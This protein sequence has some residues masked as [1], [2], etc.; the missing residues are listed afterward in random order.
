M[1]EYTNNINLEI[2]KDATETI[3]SINNC[4]S[5]VDITSYFIDIDNDLKKINFEH[6]NCVTKYKE[7]INT[8]LEKIEELK[9]ELNELQY[10]LQ[11]SCDNFTS[12]EKNQ[13][14]EIEYRT[15]VTNPTEMIHA[16]TD[17]S[18]IPPVTEQ[19]QTIENNQTEESQTTINTV[20]IG[21]G[22]A[23]TGI[24]GSVG[25]VILDSM[26]DK[27]K[28]DIEEYTMPEEEEY[29]PS[30]KGDTQQRLEP[31]F[32]DNSPYHASRNKE[33]MNKFYGTNITE[34]YEDENEEEKGNY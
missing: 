10:S 2:I 8:I 16:S 14:S 11:S 33:A 31:V 32:D 1:N 20:P 28:V 24:A 5:N 6:G 3:S 18:K 9:K 12:I 17:I 15:S 30:P 29:R 23:A 13:D 26:N 27:K 19:Q 22:I 25:A 21:L 7:N 34:Y 4:L